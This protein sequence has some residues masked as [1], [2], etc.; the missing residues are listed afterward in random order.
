ME[1]SSPHPEAEAPR[2]PKSLPGW[3]KGLLLTAALFLV[4]HPAWQGKPLWDDDAH[5][6]KS[7]LQSTT[8]LLRIWSEPGATQQYYPLTHTLF[9]LEHRIWR[10]DTEGYHLLSIALHSTTAWLLAILLLRL[11]CRAAW[12]AAAIWAL[13]PI[14][15]ESVAWMSE[16][17]NTLSGLFYLGAALAYL[18]SPV[19]EESLSIRGGGNCTGARGMYLLALGLF[20]CGLMSKSTVAT[21]P[22]VL[23]LV[24]LWKKGRVEWRRD[25]LPLTPFLAFGLISGLFTVWMEQA[26]VIGGGKL[27]A[28][29]GFLHLSPMDRILLAGRTFWFYL[30]KLC[31]PGDLIFIYPHWHLDPS[32]WQQWLYPA[33]ALLLTALLFL[34]R[35]KWGIVPLISLLCYGVTLFPAMGF[36]TVYPFRYSYVADHFQYLAG[37][38]PIALAAAGLS[39]GSLWGSGFL[40][41]WPILPIRRFTEI[42]GL[43]LLLALGVESHRLCQQYTDAE[44]LWRQTL[45]KNPTCTLALNDLGNLLADNGKTGESMT[46]FRRALE[47]EPDFGEVHCNLASVLLELGGPDNRKSALDHLERALALTPHFAEIH[48][49]LA[50][51]LLLEGNPAGAMLEY[52][53]A[54][55]LMPNSASPHLAIGSLLTQQGRW[56]EALTEF[57]QGVVLSPANAEGLAGLGSSLL[58]IGR[59]V[60]AEEPLRAALLINPNMA[61]AHN[62]LGIALLRQERR[63]EALKEFQEAVR[64]APADPNFQHNLIN[65]RGTR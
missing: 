42:L 7:T 28:S 51:I 15:V 48:L 61:M 16:L 62:N 10:D 26:Y 13:H 24:I 25:A 47:I 60:D 63:D 57:Q 39:Q 49:N 50:R 59:A 30:G 5:L 31:W 53:K 9:W 2:L 55:A 17:K 34:M 32:A 54:I 37:I 3:V 46:L 27:A 20:L 1:I 12:F 45:A 8:G 22:L 11:R 40:K 33:G 35:K 65:S 43:L 52:R 29:T 44:T 38:A 14:Q 58:G 21:L 19:G 56:D 36:I 64:L 6:T 41:G 4:Y 18:K 23:M